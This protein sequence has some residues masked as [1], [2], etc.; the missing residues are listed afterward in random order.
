MALDVATLAYA[1]AAARRMADAARRFLDTLTIEQLKRATFAFAGDERYCW[2]YTPVER[3]GL[4]LRDM[5]AAQRQA[6][7]VLLASGL[8][9][10]GATTAGAIIALE[11]ILHEWESLQRLEMPW[12]RDP[13]IYWFSVFGTPGGK[14]PWGWRAGGHH[15]GLHFTIV[16]GAQVAP[17]PLFFGANPAEVKHGPQRGTRTLADEE[18]LARALLGGLDPAQKAVAVVDA[19]APADILTKNYRVADP[20]AA[21]HGL[22][23][24]ALTGAQRER[25]VRLIRR[26][27]DRA[28]EDLAHNEWRRIEAAGL[29]A[30]TF[31]W[32]GPEARGHGHYYA[33][34]GPTFVIE[35]DNTQNDANHIH[36]VLRSFAGDWG[37]DLLAAHY[38]A[39]RHP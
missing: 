26:Y 9:A 30:V 4:R 19:I 29:E 35:Y 14:D 13:E 11:A 6:A 34:A 15:L 2:H 39:A 1:P 17:L 23:F 36:S 38:H 5:N 16:D 12:T 27:V 20:N 25:L 22:R 18:D 33:V 28:S 21:P 32:A 7:M 37:E 31:A 8:S 3:N 10:R 24:E